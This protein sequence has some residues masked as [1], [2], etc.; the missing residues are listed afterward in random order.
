MAELNER[1]DDIRMKAQAAASAVGRTD[2]VRIVPA[3]KTV[4]IEIISQLPACGIEEAGENRVQELLEKYDKVSGIKWH[5]IGALQTNKVKYIVDK[6]VLIHSVDRQALADEIERQCAKRGIKMD[7]L[8][9]IN[10]GG[11]ESKSGVSPCEAENLMSFV[12]QKE[13]L[14]L[15][16]VMSVLPKD[17]P[18][19][20]YKRLYELFLIAKERFGADIL[21]AGMS[22][23]YERAIA[24]G[25]NLIRPGTAIFG[26]R[27]YGRGV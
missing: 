1:I 8:V 12:V 16:G 6:V 18:D 19:D 11:E 25:A 20:D 13:H 2:S 23:D 5:F 3:T 21:S 10:V 27:N 14:N 4:P 17:A 15:R 7:V 24:F 26:E 9:E 22:K